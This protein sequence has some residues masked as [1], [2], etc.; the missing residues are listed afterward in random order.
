MPLQDILAS[1]TEL[2]T[3]ELSVVIAT[4]T[5]LKI[6][7]SANGG[8]RRQTK[9][10]IRGSPSK[11]GG[12]G[13]AKLDSK[14]ADVHEYREFKAAEKE[15]RSFLKARNLSLKEANSTPT[16]QDDPVLTQFR[17]AQAVWFR[18]KTRIKGTA[19]ESSPAPPKASKS[20]GRSGSSGPAQAK[21]KEAA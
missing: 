11:T 14:F 8:P 3:G 19:A 20:S 15:L 5:Q 17:T 13:P 16:I 1:L 10:G 12:K 9:S 4:A 7:R 6:E 21:G 18:F 2:T